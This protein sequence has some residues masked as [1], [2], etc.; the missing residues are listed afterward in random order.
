VV[1]AGLLAVALAGG[2]LAQGT[3]AAG[4]PAN[5]VAASG[6]TVE[7]IDAAGEKPVLTEYVKINNPTDLVISATAECAI[8]T[9]V[10]N[11][12]NGQTERAFGEV[13]M[14]VKI[15]GLV[16]P[17]AGDTPTKAS[18]PGEVVFCNRAQ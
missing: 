13:V 12:A 2:Y 15:D 10:T 9:Q 3:F 8:L 5:K 18:K 17:V 7:T 11:S 14:Y 6:S 4:T 16:V 1:A